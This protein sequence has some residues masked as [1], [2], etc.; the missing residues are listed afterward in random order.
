MRPTVDSSTSA[1]EEDTVDYEVI[2]CSVNE[3]H[4]TLGRRLT[5]LAV[6]LK[7][8]TTFNVRWTG[9]TCVPLF[10]DKSLHILHQ[11][12]FMGF[13]ARPVGCRYSRDVGLPV[14]NL[15]ELIVLGWG[16][17]AS[18]E[19]GFRLLG[20]CR[21]CG[22]MSYFTQ[23]RPPKIVDERQWDGSDFFRVW[24]VHAEMFFT[25]RVKA[26]LEQ[27]G[28]TGVEYIPGDKFHFER[29]EFGVHSLRHYYPDAR[30]REIGEPLGIY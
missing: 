3:G 2:D 7:R 16:G 8:R 21:G 29:S 30:A 15:W 10:D 4:R 27:N 12:R 19:A 24:P 23:Q 5:P 26:A 11:N 14:P 6:K 18:Q 13:E 25:D 22:R 1:L 20:S 17:I 9:F 28:I